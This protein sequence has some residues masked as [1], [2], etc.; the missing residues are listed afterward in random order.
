MKA[1]IQMVVPYLLIK[2]IM[3]IHSPLLFAVS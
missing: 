2:H 1:P 3:G